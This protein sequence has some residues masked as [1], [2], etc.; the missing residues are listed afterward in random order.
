M[1]QQN[2]Q[3]TRSFDIANKIF[4]KG[5]KLFEIIS[6]F[7][8]DYVESVLRC[9][10]NVGWTLGSGAGGYRIFIAIDQQNQRNIRLTHLV[11]M[12]RH[13]NFWS[14]MEHTLWRQVEH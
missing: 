2:S 1:K 14:S 13:A 8:L 3:T 7:A 6:K 9:V 12:Q 10:T 5:N 4:K 11:M